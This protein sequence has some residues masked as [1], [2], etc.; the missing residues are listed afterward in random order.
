MLKMYRSIT[1]SRRLIHG[2][3]RVCRI[4]LGRSRTWTWSICVSISSNSRSPVSAMKPRYRRYATFTGSSLAVAH[5]QRI[6]DERHRFPQ[7][8]PLRAT[9][10]PPQTHPTVPARFALEVRAEVKV[11]WALWR[12]QSILAHLP[13]HRLLTA[14]RHLPAPFCVWKLPAASRGKRLW[15]HLGIWASPLL[16]HLRRLCGGARLWEDRRLRERNTRRLR[17]GRQAELAPSEEAWRRCS[18]N[19]TCCPPSSLQDA[20]HL[21]SCAGL[22][23]RVQI[24]ASHRAC[25]FH[26]NLRPRR[27]PG[28][29]RAP[30]SMKRQQS[31]GLTSDGGWRAV[32]ARGQSGQCYSVEGGGRHA[33]RSR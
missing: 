3:R 23:R 24:I 16:P 32:R 25:V 8:T 29:S 33:C 30:P 11:D 17:L 7:D 5:D 14:Y 10:G 31:R 18:A 20:L 15:R 27:V 26:W 13:P 28:A 2:R 12:M 22:W 4:V 21:R 1:R 6:L 19:A 9:P